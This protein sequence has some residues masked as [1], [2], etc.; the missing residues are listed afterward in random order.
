MANIFSL[1]DV[2][3]HARVTMDSSVKNS[4]FVHRED[5]CIMEFK[6]FKSGL[7]YFDVSKHT[8]TSNFSSDSN[9]NYLPSFSLV[10]TVEDNKEKYT[11]REVKNAERARGLRRRIGPPSQQ[12]FEHYLS[13]N[14][15][16]N[17]PL[18]VADAKRAVDIFG[19]EVYSLQ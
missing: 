2:C 15:I 10:Q 19:P 12:D 18:T 3:K 14:F 11:K 6:Q 5:G 16:R 8:H 13:E 4:M 1:A 17:C 9:Y 7:Y